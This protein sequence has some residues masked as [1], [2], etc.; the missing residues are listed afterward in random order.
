MSTFRVKVEVEIEVNADNQ[1]HAENLCG[2]VVDSINRDLAF[3]KQH[4]GAWPSSV[5]CHATL[6]NLGNR[7]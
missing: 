7:K 4:I 3:L 5:K 6:I 1:G 2:V